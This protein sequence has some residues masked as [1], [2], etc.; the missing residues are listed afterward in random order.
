MADVRE[1]ANG[2][3]VAGYESR[4]Q[5][6]L[7]VVALRLPDR[8]AAG[9]DFRRILGEESDIEMQTRTKV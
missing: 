9:F 6:Y 7:G 4:K 8:L 3:I 2:L 5:G 1:K